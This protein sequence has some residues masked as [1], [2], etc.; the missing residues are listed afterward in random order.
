MIDPV[1]FINKIYYVY[2][3]RFNKFFASLDL[4]M[5]GNYAYIDGK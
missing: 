4:S 3:K 1:P 2:R 5:Y